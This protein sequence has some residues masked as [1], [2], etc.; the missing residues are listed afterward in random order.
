MCS[1]P[2]MS[3]IILQV[4]LNLCSHFI[5]FYFKL[6]TLYYSTHLSTVLYIKTLLNTLEFRSSLPNLKNYTTLHHKAFMR[7]ILTYIWVFFMYAFRY[8]RIYQYLSCMVLTQMVFIWSSDLF[9][10]HISEGTLSENW[11]TI[12]KKTGLCVR[13]YT[14]EGLCYLCKC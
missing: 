1:R 12:L 9:E 7:I 13:L 3:D 6:E 5:S 2:Q 11:L 10:N 4:S 8:Y 14:I